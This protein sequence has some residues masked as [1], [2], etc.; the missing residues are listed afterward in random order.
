MPMPL[1]VQDPTGVV[2]VLDRVG[3]SHATDP[4]L[5]NGA[6]VGVSSKMMFFRSLRASRSSP[7]DKPDS[8]LMRSM[9]FCKAESASSDIAAEPSFSGI[10]SP[11]SETLSGQEPCVGT[12]VAEPKPAAPC[13]CAKTEGCWLEGAVARVGATGAEAVALEDTRGC[14][15]RRTICARCEGGAAALEA[16]GLLRVRP[17]TPG[18]VLRTPGGARGEE[19][20]LGEEALDDEGRCAG[21]GLPSGLDDTLGLTPLGC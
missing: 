3:R 15:G 7:R 4:L 10:R 19:A 2:K 6:G 17:R 13:A 14:S 8:C 16:F 20:S 11:N 21:L 18:M 5:D 9:L 12:A 1:P